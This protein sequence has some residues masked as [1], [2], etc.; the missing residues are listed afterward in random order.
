MIVYAE[1]SPRLVREAAGI[2]TGALREAAALFRA[3]GEDYHERNLEEGFLFPELRRSAAM[4][5]I[6]ST[7]C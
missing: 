6:R 1:T 2:D 3:F 5:A 4:P 7:P